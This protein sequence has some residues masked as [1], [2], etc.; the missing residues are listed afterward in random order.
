MLFAHLALNRANLSRLNYLDSITACYANE[1][2]TSGAYTI[3][4]SLVTIF[5]S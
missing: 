4:Y 5:A 2:G 3:E 1:K